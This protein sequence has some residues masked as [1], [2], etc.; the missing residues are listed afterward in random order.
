MSTEQLN[1][2]I[3]LVT[4]AS[5]GIGRAIALALAEAGADVAANYQRNEVAAMEVCTRIQKMGQRT[6]PAQ[7]DVARTLDVARMVEMVR[8]ELGPITILVNNAGI[9]MVRTIDEITE[10]DWNEMLAVNLKASFLVTQGS[11]A[12]HA[13]CRLGADHGPLLRGRPDGRGGR[14]P[15][16]RLQG[17]DRGGERTDGDELD[18]VTAALVERWYLDGKG[19]L[20]GG[21]DGRS[22]TGKGKRPIRED[23]NGTA[24]NN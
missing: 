5:R 22:V 8:R 10:K 6:V 14:P 19:V 13:C 1:G 17:G 4:G 15:L 21:E 23:S 18:A 20:L 16:R 12:G 11:V 3:A 24:G 2:K 7:C 9:G